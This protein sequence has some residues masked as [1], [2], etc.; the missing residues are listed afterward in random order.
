MISLLKDCQGVS[1][2]ASQKQP[3]S[4]TTLKYAE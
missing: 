3:Q 1:F 2:K 4:F